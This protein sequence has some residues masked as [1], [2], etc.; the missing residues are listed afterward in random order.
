MTEAPLRIVLVDDEAPAR[1]RLRE[2]L[3]DCTAALPVLVVGEA[4]S[5]REALHLLGT[6]PADLVLTDIHMPDMDGIELARHL[7]KLPLPPVLIFTTA[8]HEHAIAAFEVHAIDYLVKPVR[9]QRL[10]SALQKVPRLKPLS[11]TK[12]NRLPA[13]A[14]RFLSVTERSRVVLV[15]IDE[16]VYLKAELKYITIRTA[17]REFLLEESLTRLEEE[18][19]PRFV[20][21]HRNCL[22][23]RE[24]IRGFERRV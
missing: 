6:T 5:G 14:R 1:R 24:A 17:D 13:A 12:L 4:G 20:R 16:I 7:L 3:D 23:A 8:Y 22:V 15:P 2:L 11:D 9:V 19:G 18:F 21:V 10:L